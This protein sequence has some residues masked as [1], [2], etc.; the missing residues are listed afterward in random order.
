MKVETTAWQRRV[1]IASGAEEVNFWRE[2]FR[3]DPG[4]AGF[5]ADFAGSA[6]SSRKSV[7]E[8]VPAGLVAH[9]ASVSK[10]SQRKLSII[11]MAGIAVVASRYS[12]SRQVVIGAEGDEEA[13]GGSG[14]FPVM[15]TASGAI[16]FR[17]NMKRIADDLRSANAH[18]PYPFELLADDMER[19]NGAVNPFYD[20][21]VIREARRPHLSAPLAPAGINVYWAATETGKHIAAS[22]DATRFKEGTVRTVLRL[23]VRCLLAG[24]GDQETTLDEIALFDSEEMKGQQQVR[25]VV[26]GVE[27]YSH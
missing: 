22:Y 9:L 5:A 12:G 7:L 13:D 8:P 18:M 25:G 20:I 3:Q 4:N 21:S 10:G 2:K 6:V 26:S 16:S 27:S 1:A 24:L 11:M 17:R 19:E 14:V 15:V 23:T